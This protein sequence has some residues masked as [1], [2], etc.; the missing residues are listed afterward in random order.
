MHHILF[1]AKY[2]IESQLDFSPLTCCQILPRAENR[3]FKGTKSK[4][5]KVLSRLLLSLL[6]FSLKRELK[7]LNLLL[8]M[9][10]RS[11]NRLTEEVT[12]K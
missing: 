3:A 12:E 2:T 4:E 5:E 8:P 10:H 7:F 6:L 11:V 9:V 1:T